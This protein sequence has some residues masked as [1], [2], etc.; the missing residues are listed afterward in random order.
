M[1][2]CAFAATL[3]DGPADDFAQVALAIPTVAALLL[4][5]IDWERMAFG[6]AGFSGAA[7]L[8]LTVAGREASEAI[9]GYDLSFLVNWAII[10]IF[11]GV[12]VY[13]I[14]FVWGAMGEVRRG[15]DEMVELRHDRERETMEPE[16]EPWG[17]KGGSGLDAIGTIAGV[18]VP[19]IDATEPPS[20]TSPLNVA[21]AAER[22][23]NFAAEELVASIEAYQVNGE[24]WW[25]CTEPHIMVQYRD[26]AQME[27]ES[28]VV[29][30]FGWARE[31]APSQKQGARVQRKP[32]MFTF[33]FAIGTKLPDDDLTVMW[34]RAS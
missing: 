7:V 34:S 1:A 3:V 12:P 29:P 26:R 27:L 30:F 28:R 21:A 4:C 6:A 19:G 13:G 11:S 8:G 5:A 33:Q 22:P 31:S 15:I 16:A 18:P 10:S 9:T 2:V 23:A 32:G 17:A 25:K 14:W 24:P 20:S